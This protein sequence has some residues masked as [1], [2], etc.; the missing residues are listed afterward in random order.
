MPSNSSGESTPFH[1][2]YL[3]AV[4]AYPNKT[5]KTV[6]AETG[7]LWSE[8]KEKKKEFD[9]EL[10]KLQLKATKSRSSMLHFWT[11]RPA[12]T[13]DT[14]DSSAPDISIVNIVEPE[15]VNSAP[16][17]ETGTPCPT[18]TQNSRAVGT[19]DII[20]L[21]IFYEV[22]VGSV[23]PITVKLAVPHRL[24]HST[25]DSVKVQLVVLRYSW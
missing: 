24:C 12:P 22:T 19:I 4:K 2:L 5:K 3:A 13:T 20:S 25:V 7:I 14:A 1:K 18:D 10:K 6:Q 16:E 11:S 21:F 17:T 9:E 23:T 15:P 8:I